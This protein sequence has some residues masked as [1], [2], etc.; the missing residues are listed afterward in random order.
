MTLCDPRDCYLP[1]SSEF[2]RE[3]YWNGVPFPTS[4][5]LPHPGIEPACLASP[6]LTGDSWQVLYHYCHLGSLLGG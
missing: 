3:E 2:S 6:A 5:D 1:D 4:E